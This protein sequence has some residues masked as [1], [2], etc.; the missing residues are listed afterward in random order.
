MTIMKRPFIAPVLALSADNQSHC[1][2]GLLQEMSSWWLV[3]VL[4]SAR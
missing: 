3:I 2:V 1:I 4:L